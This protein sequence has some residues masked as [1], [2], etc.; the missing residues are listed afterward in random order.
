MKQTIWRVD[1][2]RTIGG[3]PVRV[4][5]SPRVIDTPQGPAVQFDGRGD[6]LIIDANPLEGAAAFTLEAV[7]RPDSGGAPE[8]RFVHIQ[9]AD[10]DDRILLETRL[11]PAGRWYADTFIRSNGRQV[12]LNDPALLHDLDQ[13][14]TMALV[15]D[16][17]EMVQY[18]DGRR[19]LS[20]GIDYAPQRVGQVS[21]GA[22]INRVWWFKGAIRLLRFTAAALP[23]D[24]LLRVTP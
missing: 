22:R 17:R 15:C 20:A 14:H 7:F 19:E 9:Q 8:Q 3:R 1:N 16:G 4:V 12:P 11:A 18:V 24:R 10:C 21:L 13:W 6:Q 23:A 2:P 5:G